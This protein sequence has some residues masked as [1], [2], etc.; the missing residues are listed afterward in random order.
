MPARRQPQTQRQTQQQPQGPVW[1]PVHR[2]TFVQR[3]MRTGFMTKATALDIF[4]ELTGS[5][6]GAFAAPRRS[7]CG[8]VVSN[9]PAASAHICRVLLPLVGHDCLQRLSFRT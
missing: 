8:A 7:L 5:D 6:S 3:L 1:Q 2:L 9:L 4:E